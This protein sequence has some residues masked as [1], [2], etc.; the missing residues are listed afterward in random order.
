MLRIGDGF[1]KHFGPLGI[2]GNELPAV[3]VGLK[4]HP[5]FFDDVRLILGRDFQVPLETL[6]HRGVRH[7]RRADVGGRKSGVPMK[8]VG[9]GVKA[10]ALGVVGDANLRGRKFGDPFNGASV[11]GTHVGCG[12]Q[13]DWHASVRKLAQS[14]HEQ[15][16]AGPFNEGYQ[17]VH[18][19]G[20]GHFES[21]LVGEWRIGLGTGEQTALGE[22]GQRPRKP[23][24]RE[25]ARRDL[26]KQLRPG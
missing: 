6:R 14:I 15:S 17:D 5:E 19:I 20:G 3:P 8:M 21:Q 25:V 18:S 9:L 4:F 11:R 22:R 26:G 7:V 12:D 10:R 1:A 24:S 13:P 23:G 16:Q 2:E